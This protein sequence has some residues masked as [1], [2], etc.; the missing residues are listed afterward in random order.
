VRI[1]RFIVDKLPQ[2]IRKMLLNSHSLYFL[3]SLF[4]NYVAGSKLRFKTDEI[5]K[6][7][8]QTNENLECAKYLPEMFGNYIDV[9][10]G[11][12]V[13][14]SNTFFLYKRRW[15]GIA[16]DPIEN[17]KR[18]F[19]ILRRRDVFQK[20]L[21]GTQ[22]KGVWFYEVVPYLYSTTSTDFVTNLIAK[23]GKIKSEI[24]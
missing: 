4:S 21:I 13:Y 24:F 17:N 1:L 5:D 11:Q 23:D 10:A 12:P 7:F 8:S 19:N 16:I 2:S 9:G 20:T 15:N 6:G 22:G 14:G 18:L 3:W